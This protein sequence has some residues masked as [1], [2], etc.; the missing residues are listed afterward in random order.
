MVVWIKVA[1][2]YG[3]MASGRSVVVILSQAWPLTQFCE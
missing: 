1:A 2:Q 3:Q